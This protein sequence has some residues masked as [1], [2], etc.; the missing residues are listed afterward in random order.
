V[1]ISR[2]KENQNNELNPQGS[3][4]LKQ[5]SA[6]IAYTRL[7]RKRI[8]M[9]RKAVEAFGLWR[10]DEGNGENYDPQ[11]TRRRLIGSVVAGVDEQDRNGR[12]HDRPIPAWVFLIRVYDGGR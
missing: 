2:R 12:A 5:S 3:K 10:H 8:L 4:G 6:T 11:A 9:K 1:T 7:F